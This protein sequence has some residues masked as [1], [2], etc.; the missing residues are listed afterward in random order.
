V[1]QEFTNI[2]LNQCNGTGGP[3]G[4]V[5]RQTFETGWR[6]SLQS[7]ANIGSV[8]PGL[9]MPVRTGHVLE[10]LY[11]GSCTM[12]GV[13]V[14]GPTGIAVAA[15]MT[16][17]DGTIFARWTACAANQIVV[18]NACQNCPANHN[19]N[20]ARTE[21]IG[22]TIGITYDSRGGVPTPTAPAS[23]I[24]GQN[25]TLPAEPTLAGFSF[26]GWHMYLN[27]WEGDLS[28]TRIGG[29]S[30]SVACSLLGSSGNVTLVA[31]WNANTINITYNS[32]G[33]A[34]TPTAPA[35]CL[36][37][38]DITL[39]AAPTRTG[40]TFGGWRIGTTHI[41]NSGQTVACSLL[42]TGGNITLTAHW[43]PITYT[44]NFDPNGGIGV[45]GSIT[46]TFGNDCWPPAN[47]F[48]RLGYTFLRWCSDAAGTLNCEVPTTGGAWENLR[49]TQGANITMFAIWGGC[50]ERHTSDPAT[51]TCMP[52]PAPPAITRNGVI[53]DANTRVVNNQCEWR[54]T[55][56]PR[57]NFGGTTTYAGATESGWTTDHT[58]LVC[59]PNA[60][61]FTFLESGPDG[62]A[63]C[64]LEQMP[65]TGTSPT[66][67]PFRVYYRS[68]HI[69]PDGPF[70]RTGFNT[71]SGSFLWTR[72]NPAGGWVSSFPGG[73]IDG[74]S[75]VPTM[76][77]HWDEL[78]ENHNWNTTIEVRWTP[79]T[80]TITFDSRGG[81]PVSPATYTVQA[82][83]VS[84]P[85]A[86]KNNATF[87]G[88]TLANGQPW[89]R[90]QCE[91][92]GDVTL[93]ANWLCNAG[94]YMNAMGDCVP[95]RPGYWS[96]ANDNIS[97]A[98]P[99]DTEFNRTIGSVANAASPEDCYVMC[100]LIIVPNS[101][102]VDIYTPTIRY[103][104]GYSVCLYEFDC[105]AGFD[106][107]DANAVP[108]ITTANG[109]VAPNPVCEPSIINI[110]YRQNAPGTVTHMPLPHICIMGNSCIINHLMQT[111][112]RAGHLF[113]G[114]G[115]QGEW[116]G[117]LLQGGADGWN[118]GTQSIFG[119]TSG[120]VPFY[121]QWDACSAGTFS[122]ADMLTC[123]ECPNGTFNV[124][125]GNSV[126]LPCGEGFYNYDTGNTECLPISYTVIFDDAFGG[127]FGT[128]LSQE[129]VWNNPENLFAVAFS[130]PGFEFM[131]WQAIDGATGT[132]INQ[133]IVENLT[134]ELGATITMQAQWRACRADF[135]TVGAR[136]IRS[137]CP[138]GTHLS[139]DGQSCN[140][141]IQTCVMA[142]GRT[143]YFEWN[144]DTESMGPCVL[145]ICGV[146]QILVGGTCVC[147]DNNYHPCG[148]QG[149]E[150]CA[151][152]Q[153]CQP[154]E[155]ECIPI[156]GVR[157]CHDY[158]ALD[159]ER[160]FNHITGEFGAC[161]PTDC[162][163]EFHVN[164]EFCVPSV[165]DCDIY[166]GGIRTGRG[167]ETWDGRRWGECIATHCN[168][169]WTNERW[170]TNDH[171]SQCGRCR[172]AFG[173]F[174]EDINP[175]FDANLPMQCVI[176][177]CPDQD[178]LYNL[179]TG[180]NECIPICA[181]D[182][183]S[184]ET[185]TMS[186]NPITR[187]CE[188]ICADGFTHW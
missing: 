149:R 3:T 102:F 33:G 146:D 159:G 84:N 21:C 173:V 137:Y 175:T 119:H 130:R 4:A 148:Y 184:D 29:G 79:I 22:N 53:G 35:S 15:P 153:A 91:T 28:A 52:C 162:V 164:G 41:G 59:G 99:A 90:V 180:R 85:T 169:G 171:T 147:R 144:P 132:F 68:G 1:A 114:W 13:R 160:R 165:Q 54:I 110:E 121:A 179:D 124:G 61:N 12:V 25:F 188:I 87:N 128:M 176:T 51:N 103:D 156:L 154:L 20:V 145:R 185:G 82:V 174:G 163:S 73:R 97:H 107:T 129:M 46:C 43:T 93:V 47:T 100:E 139:S 181:V 40:H 182:G 136:C 187:R 155:F 116:T 75:P 133:E 89:N 17:N 57:H 23:C 60:V 36:F 168:P 77:G 80:Y 172:N 14:I 56:N 113:I 109:A 19:P 158:N 63:T 178:Q 48:V 125:H 142:D 64:S 58:S 62:T 88:W 104:N 141:N 106:R 31:R 34:P 39:P 78:F 70:T 134:N 18:N 24:F 115:L 98:C 118:P 55:C 122:T 66:P 26:I 183:T 38:Q 65:F 50:P 117:E 7:H 8:I 69:A 177:A 49:N 161:I 138:T 71:A 120:T 42:G 92:I 143:G 105:N 9:T 86:T 72:R 44:V 67:N 76:Q 101:R 5:F 95:T 151:N 135:H 83:N 45:Q 11:T 10:G 111:P 186:W 108:L 81:N 94:F 157:T 152:V 170:L 126:C 150:C 30:E 140:P 6:M 112:L 32:A 131:R 96:G 166:T 16:S 74:D 167:Q 27:R 2:S 127:Q 37:N 123:E